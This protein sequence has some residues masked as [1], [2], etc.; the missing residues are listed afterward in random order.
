MS[1]CIVNGFPSDPEKMIG[2]SMI[3]DGYASIN[4]K[5][6]IYGVNFFNCIRKV[7]QSMDKSMLFNCNRVKAL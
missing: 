7:A 5:A 4:F 1:N 2:D 3:F 6:T